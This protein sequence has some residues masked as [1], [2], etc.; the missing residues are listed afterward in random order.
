MRESESGATYQPVL[1]AA[2]RF[3]GSGPQPDSVPCRAPQP[4]HSRASSASFLATFSAASSASRDRLISTDPLLISSSFALRSAC[5]FCLYA[6]KAAI[7]ASA[8][9]KSSTAAHRAASHSLHRSSRDSFRLLSSTTAFFSF[10]CDF[11]QPPTAPPTAHPV[12]STP[13][14]SAARPSA[15]SFSAA[16]SLSFRAMSSASCR[17]CSSCRALLA[18]SF[19]LPLAFDPSS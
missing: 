12:V 2:I 5:A 18:S 17:S 15:R 13:H 11:P 16:I 7:W 19:T 10:P 4:P 6:A 1:C 8:L 9:R 3:R 14:R